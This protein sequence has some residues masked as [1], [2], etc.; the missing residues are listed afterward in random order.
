MNVNKPRPLPI[1]VQQTQSD[2]PVC[3][4]LHRRCREFDPLT[5]HHFGVKFTDVPISLHAGPSHRR[6]EALVARVDGNSAVGWAEGDVRDRHCE[7][8]SLVR[9]RS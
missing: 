5:A 9:G 8:V 4:R 7:G 3:R 2:A 1:K 6:G